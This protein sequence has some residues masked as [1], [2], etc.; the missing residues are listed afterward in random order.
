METASKTTITVKSIINA[1]IEKVWECWTNPEH[2][3]QWCQASEDWHAPYA[4]N[5]IRT[6]GKFKTTM[7]AKDGSFSFDFEGVYS[8]V[9]EHRLIE[10]SMP[11]GRKV[12]I[13]FVSEGDKTEVM[14]TFDPE[15][16]NSLEMQQG[17]WQAILDSFK[18]H[19]EAA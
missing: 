17:G 5:D 11:D 13:S 10:Y 15:S 14:E 19:T 4:D 18:K 6:G 1:P 16:I 2:I 3:T 7:A 8:N 12:K 9:E